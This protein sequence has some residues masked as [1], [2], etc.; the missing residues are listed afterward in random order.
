MADAQYNVEAAYDL[1][2][3]VEQ[4]TEK[5]IKWYLLSA[6]QNHAWAQYNFAIYYLDGYGVPLDHERQ[7][8]LLNSGTAMPRIILRRF[9]NKGQGVEKSPE[10][11]IA[12][13][14]VA[15]INGSEP[16]QKLDTLKNLYRQE[17]SKALFR[18][19]RPAASFG[20]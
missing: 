16:A 9:T 4:S 19:K 20:E 1:G 6:E 15:A 2:Q 7:Q 17:I 10:K 8:R 11:V 13:F 18:M 5:A 3:G 12:W 14:I